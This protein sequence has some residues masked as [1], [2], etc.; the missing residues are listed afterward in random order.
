MDSPG[1]DATRAL[2]LLSADGQVETRVDDVDSD[3]ITLVVGTWAPT[4]PERG[5][6][7]ARLRKES[8]Q[9]LHDA[10]LSSVSTG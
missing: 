5:G 2:E 1:G 10:G 9:R 4:P 8:L 6:V 3:G 7:A